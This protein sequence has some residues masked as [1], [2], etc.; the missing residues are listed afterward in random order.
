M[1]L[2]VPALHV[3]VGL[4]GVAGSCG[5]HLRMPALF[6]APS[7]VVRAWDFFPKYLC[8]GTG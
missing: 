8:A 4:T 3:L 5:G 7:P 6:G 2:S 1:E